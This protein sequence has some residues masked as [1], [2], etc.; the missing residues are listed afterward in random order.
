MTRTRVGC[1][2]V[3]TFSQPESENATASESAAA[4]ASQGSVNCRALSIHRFL[5][6]FIARI[7]SYGPSLIHIVQG[8]IEMSLRLFG[9]AVGARF[10]AVKREARFRSQAAVKASES[11]RRHYR[12]K[13]HAC[14]NRENLQPVLQVEAAGLTDEQVCN[15]EVEEPPEDV[16]GGGGQALAGRLCEWRLERG[17]RKFRCQYGAGHLQ[18]TLPRRSRQDSDTSASWLR[19]CSEQNVSRRQS[20]SMITVPWPN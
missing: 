14:A 13:Q 5:L 8:G 15:G 2:K 16:D 7:F 17:G 1:V 6:V 20:R 4:T 19:F 10:Q 3:A 9:C 18:E 11:S 12:Y